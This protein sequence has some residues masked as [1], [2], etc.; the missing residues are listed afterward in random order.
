MRKRT[1]NPGKSG[2][3]NPSM[4][5]RVADKRGR[6]RSSESTSAI[7]EATLRL[8]KEHALRDIT[9]E[10]IAKSAGVGKTT[11]Y[12]WWPSKAFVALE[13]FGLEMRR[14]VLIPDTG[15]A[16]RDF[17]EQLQSVIKFYTSKTG[18]IF[19]QFLAECQSDVEFA[20]LFRERFLSPRRAAVQVIWERGVARK[21]IDSTIDMDTV[22]DLIYGPMIFRLMAG[23]ALLNAKEA[24]GIVAAAFRGL[25]T[26]S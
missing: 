17:S 25:G 26:K 22:L 15:S 7:L 21:Q 1:D 13:A 14:D 8:L 24:A 6:P 23:H 9:I 3:L 4:E 20:A 12:K 11:I 5:A 16:E 19:S 18:R 10:M 2:V